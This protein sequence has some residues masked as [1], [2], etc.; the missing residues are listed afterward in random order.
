MP[1]GVHV[2]MPEPAEL[3]AAHLKGTGA[4]WLGECDVVGA[5]HR[6]GL[7]TEFDRPEGVDDIER[8]DVELDLAVDR[9]VKRGRLDAT[10]AWVTERPQPLLAD[11][12]NL[13]RTAPV[14]GLGDRVR[15]LT[16]AG[17]A[18]G[19]QVGPVPN[20]ARPSTSALVAISQVASI[21]R[22]PVIGGPSTTAGPLWR[23]TVT[24]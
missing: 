9:Q 19:Q 18:R 8:C 20:T 3:V 16:P 10:V 14:G 15:S 17:A 24:A 2:A 4:Q 7:H 21:R 1:G 23:K 11:H 22:L 5:L 6:I 13:E 12:L